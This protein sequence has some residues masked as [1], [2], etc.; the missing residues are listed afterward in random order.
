MYKIY[1]QHRLREQKKRVPLSLY[2]TPLAY[3]AHT[4]CIQAERSNFGMHTHQSS[5]HNE[6]E[7]NGRFPNFKLLLV[8]ENA[9][10]MAQ[11]FGSRSC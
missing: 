11:I 6:L 7:D 4:Y 1:V 10:D 5:V 8:I 9:E 3:A 2:R